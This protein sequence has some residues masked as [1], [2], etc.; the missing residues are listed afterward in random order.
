MVSV[1][2]MVLNLRSRDT[3]I[4]QQDNDTMDAVPPIQFSQSR[5]LGDIGAPIMV[6]IEWDDKTNSEMNMND[7][8]RVNWLSIQKGLKKNRLN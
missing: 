8:P 2:N 4:T 1:D 5:F 3:D 6:S 7:S